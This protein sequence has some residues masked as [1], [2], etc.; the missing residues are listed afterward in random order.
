MLGSN[1]AGHASFVVSDL[2]DSD[3]LVGLRLIGAIL[4]EHERATS[5]V[6]RHAFA[7]VDLRA[8]CREVVIR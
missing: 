8:I 5:F 2:P 3:D 1:D 4:D 7:C 6:S